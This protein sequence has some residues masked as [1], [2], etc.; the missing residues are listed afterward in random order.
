LRSGIGIITHS[1]KNI[2][3]IEDRSSGRARKDIVKL[4]SGVNASSQFSQRIDA[5]I[6]LTGS[7]KITNV[8]GASAIFISRAIKAEIALIG[9]SC[10]STISV[11]TSHRVRAKGTSTSAEGTFRERS[12]E[13][14]IRGISQNI[15]KA[16]ASG[17]AHL[18]I[19][20]LRSNSP[21]GTIRSSRHANVINAS[22]A[23]FT[24]I[25]GNYGTITS[26]RNSNTLVAHASNI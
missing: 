25:R 15:V 3:S 21:A 16:V 7:V 18:I 22:W 12:D 4:A 5:N 20:N 10:G 23:R 1:K 11:Q 19:G 14:T 8:P 2:V 6:L 17:R 9:V 24:R 26:S 13:N